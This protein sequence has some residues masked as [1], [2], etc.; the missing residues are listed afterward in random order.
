MGAALR[1]PALSAAAVVV[2]GGGGGGGGGV[3]VAGGAETKTRR[4]T[5]GSQI[6]RVDSLGGSRDK[7]YYRCSLVEMVTSG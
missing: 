6:G 7:L 1:A 3:V 4:W 2:G 5:P